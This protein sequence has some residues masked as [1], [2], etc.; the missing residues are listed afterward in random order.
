MS[1]A[2]DII[3]KLIKLAIREVGIPHVV[4][5]IISDYA[6]ET[7]RI[8]PQI[9][10]CSRTSPYCP[11]KDCTAERVKIRKAI[12]NLEVCA[13]KLVAAFNAVENL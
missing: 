12:E 9:S 8:L 5:K 3:D 13:D 2:Q 4:Q 10:A 6:D 1:P 7:M 11:C